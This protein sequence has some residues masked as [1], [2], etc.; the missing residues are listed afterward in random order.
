M[1]I[2]NNPLFIIN[3]IIIGKKLN[4]TFKGMIRCG[5]VFLGAG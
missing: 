4:K 1:K 3:K 5:A 2:S